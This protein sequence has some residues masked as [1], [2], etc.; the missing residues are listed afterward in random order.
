MLWV[1]LEPREHLE[2]GLMS[3][4]EG[5]NRGIWVRRVFCHCEVGREGLENR[6]YNFIAVQRWS[7][8]LFSWRESTYEKLITALFSGSARATERGVALYVSFP[9]STTMLEVPKCFIIRAVK[10]RR[11]S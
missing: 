3:K 5:G 4:L 7:V 10:R 9:T 2:M 6:I 11:I 1:S 8:Y